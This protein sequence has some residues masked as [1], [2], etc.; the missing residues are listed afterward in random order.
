[1]EEETKDKVHR[2]SKTE[3]EKAGERKS[4]ERNGWT[5]EM[6]RLLAEQGLDVQILK[7]PDFHVH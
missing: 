7:C 5:K 6:E 4:R 2:E 3:Q 1:M